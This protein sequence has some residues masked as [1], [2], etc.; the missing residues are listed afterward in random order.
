MKTKEEIFKVASLRAL[1]VAV[2]A[3]GLMVFLLLLKI[4]QWITT[5]LVAG[6]IVIML[7]LYE[8][9]KPSYK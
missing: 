7:M 9:I 3:I 8:K 6:F 4:P 1:T 2:I 5:S